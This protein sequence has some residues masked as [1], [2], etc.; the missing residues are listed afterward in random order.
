MLQYERI[1]VSEGIDVN[2][3][4]ASKECMLFHYRYFKKIGYKFK[5][6]VCDGCHDILMIAY[7]LKNVAI[8]K[9]KRC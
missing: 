8:L 9:V 7:E 5:P 6:R 1:D 4:R 2:K 3:A